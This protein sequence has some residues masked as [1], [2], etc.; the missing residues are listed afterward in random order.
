MPRRLVSCLGVLVLVVA[1]TAVDHAS[2]APLR[3]RAKVEMGVTAYCVD[4]ETAA[5]TETRRGVVAADPD[6][7]PLGSRV[8]VRGLGRGHDRDYKV[9]DTGRAV[10][11][12]EL[13][14]FMRDCGAAKEFGRRTA[15]VQVLEVG[16]G[17]ADARASAGKR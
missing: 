1:S 3:R 12:R 13:D 11:G 17:A 4:G 7:L 2:G 15:R 14:I 6:V 9:E 16:K 5:G 8:R 10:K